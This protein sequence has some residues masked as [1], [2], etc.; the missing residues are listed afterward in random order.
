MLMEQ[1]VIEPEPNLPLLRKV[2]EYAE[3]H[4][5]QFDMDSWYIDYAGGGWQKTLR[6]QELQRPLCNTTMCAAGTAAWLVGA[7]FGPRNG[8]CTTPDGREATILDFATEV[9][10]LTTAQAARIFYSGVKTGQELRRQI[11][12]VLE[13]T[14]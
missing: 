4:P 1:L 10:G 12:R 5:D 2:V 3:A 8:W 11:E 7:Q 9:L 6:E 13:V 14:L